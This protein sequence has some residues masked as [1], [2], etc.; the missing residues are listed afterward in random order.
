MIVH[1]D[2]FET[3]LSEG[4][5]VIDFASNLNPFKPRDL[6]EKILSFVD[7]SFFYPHNDYATLIDVISD[8]TGWDAKNVVFGNGSIELIEFFFRILKRD[9][10]IVYPTF[11][12]YERFARIYGLRVYNLEWN[13]E[14]ILSFIRE[15]KPEGLVICN[16]NNPT[17]DFFRKSEMNEISE[18]C[19]STET[20]L[21]IDQAFMDFVKPYDV[22][23]FQIRSLTK[24]LGIPGLRFGYGFFPE[25]FGKIFHE[26]RMPWNV[27]GI[28][29]AVAEEYLPKLM[30]FSRYVRRRISKERS[31][32]KNGLKRLGF[33]S[34]GKAN[35]LLCYGNHNAKKIFDFL[36]R[37]SIII[38]KCEDFKGLTE[39]HFRIAVRKRE[40]N[41]ELLRSLE[42]FV[43]E[44]S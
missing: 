36:E 3:Y 40:E 43:Q 30:P 22:Y 31:H 6:R 38:R 9:V 11:T 13:L 35:F 26:F 10:A 37:N 20:K 18:L 14:Q 41:R 24:I 28:A 19:L 2:I 29:K 33:S 17:G 4:K 7:S 1:G 23:G 21:M 44:N 12:E 39:N 27:N 15:K 8:S 25:N 32:L 42:I 34:N 5:R 16:P